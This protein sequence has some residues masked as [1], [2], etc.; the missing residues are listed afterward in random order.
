MLEAES[1]PLGG[2][3]RLGALFEVVGSL[4]IRLSEVQQVQR[5]AGGAIVYDL[6][7]EE[8]LRLKDKLL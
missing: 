5:G 3:R 6:E 8:L 1:R 7:E 2:E 4:S